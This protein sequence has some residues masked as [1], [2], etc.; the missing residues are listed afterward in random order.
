MLGI[1][2]SQRQ[3]AEATLRIAEARLEHRARVELRDYR[4]LQGERFDKVVSLGMFEHVGRKNLP[5][6]FRA[7]Y[8]ALRPGGL[9][10][11][12]G[13]ALGSDDSYD[14]K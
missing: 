7:A 13:I 6:Y 2:L 3:Y 8:D 14:G 1:T 10:L 5:R 4:D 12:A 9:F 11:N